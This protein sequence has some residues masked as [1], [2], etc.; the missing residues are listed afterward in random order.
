MCIMTW[1]GQVITKY[2]T[3]NLET[4]EIAV[5]LSEVITKMRLF[6]AQRKQHLT[7]KWLI[8]QILFFLFLNASC[9]KMKVSGWINVILIATINKLCTWRNAFEAVVQVP[10]LPVW[11]PRVLPQ[12]LAGFVSQKCQSLIKNN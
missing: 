1:N 4:N 2:V 11:R 6:C 7:W 8:L 5:W 3:L 10:D 12:S 9:S